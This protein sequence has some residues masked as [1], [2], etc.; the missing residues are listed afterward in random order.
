MRKSSRRHHQQ[1]RHS[2]SYVSNEQQEQN[3]QLIKGLDVS[4]NALQALLNSRFKIIDLIDLIKKIHP[5]LFSDD[6]KRQLQFI[7]Q[8]S[9]TN[10]GE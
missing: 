7:E 3:N 2:A 6:Q 5:K 10:T 4:Q 9:E 8:L 1:N